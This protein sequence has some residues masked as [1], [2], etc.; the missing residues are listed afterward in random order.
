META[1]R[2]YSAVDFTEFVGNAK[3][4]S[5]NSGDYASILGKIQDDFISKGGK[6]CNPSRCNSCVCS[7]CSR[8]RCSCH[9][10]ED[11]T[12]TIW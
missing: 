8:P 10:W 5:P 9:M 7:G 6:P 3:V 2:D 11:N 1:I 12:Y 4:I